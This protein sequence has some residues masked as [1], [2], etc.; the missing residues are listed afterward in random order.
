MPHGPSA[1]TTNTMPAQRRPDGDQAQAHVEGGTARRAIAPQ[2][3]PPS[4]AMTANSTEN[5]ALFH[6]ETVRM[7]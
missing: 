6:V 2:A 4:S 1:H 7:V 3:T 5:A